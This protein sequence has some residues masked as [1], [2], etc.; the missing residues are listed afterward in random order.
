VG[1][2]DKRDLAFLEIVERGFDSIAMSDGAGAK[3]G[4]FAPADLYEIFTGRLMVNGCYDL[5]SATRALDNGHADAISLGRPFIS[6]PDVVERYRAGVA[7]NEDL[8][9]VA[10][11]GGGEE[12]YCDLPAMP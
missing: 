6:T 3:A 10:W 5:E 9:P 8:N 1:E 12:G 2:L 11:Y 7:L 4:E